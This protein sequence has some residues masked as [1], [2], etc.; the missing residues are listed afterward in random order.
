MTRPSSSSQVHI[1]LLNVQCSLTDKAPTENP[2]AVNPKLEPVT[3]EPKPNTDTNSGDNVNID[4]D[5][6]VT[7]KKV[8]KGK[9]KA[10]DLP[11]NLEDP[12]P[13]VCYNL[14]TQ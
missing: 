12:A 8:D 7:L 6:M 2:R 11:E 3:P 14:L 13:R 1:S 9:A 10:I 4:V 5:T